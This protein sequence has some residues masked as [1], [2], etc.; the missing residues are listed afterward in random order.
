MQKHIITKLVSILHSMLWLAQLHSHSQ[1]RNGC[2]TVTW[3][4]FVTSMYRPNPRNFSTEPIWKGFAITFG[5]CCKALILVCLFHLLTYSESSFIFQTVQTTIGNPTINVV[6]KL[7]KVSVNVNVAG[8]FVFTSKLLNP[9]KHV[10]WYSNVFHIFT[11]VHTHLNCF[12]MFLT[13]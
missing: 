4:H 10:S 8:G 9:H 1:P 7:C 12:E 6:R 3:Y 2:L 11:Y 13:Y 5:W